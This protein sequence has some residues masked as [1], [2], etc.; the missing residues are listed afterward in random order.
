MLHCPSS[1]CKLAS[2]IAPIPE[3]MAQGVRVSLGADGAACNNNLDAF[4]EMRL[5]ALIHKPRFGPQALPAQDV[6]RMATRSGAAA[7]GLDDRIGSI[8]VGK[9]ADLVLLD[10]NQA[11]T[12]PASNHNL[13]SRI[14]YAARA[15]DVRHV[16]VAG[17]QVV[18]DG[19]L[20]TDD[21]ARIVSRAD[22]ALRQ[23]AA[24]IG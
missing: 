24:A 14:V 5:A 15:S 9:Q 19:V 2:G 4:Q 3:M 1:N 18:R 7:L 20:L 17:R 16:F 8:E 13:I 11:H 10:L 22:Q 21:E 12:Q 6:L 23:L